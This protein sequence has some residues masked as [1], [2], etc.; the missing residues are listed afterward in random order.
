MPNKTWWIIAF[1]DK[2]ESFYMDVDKHELTTMDQA[3]RFDGMDFDRAHIALLDIRP[4][5]RK[6]AE[7]K[8][9]SVMPEVQAV[10]G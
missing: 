5:K 7:G 2:G 3:T 1:H 6:D 10:Q 4:L 8:E 9:Y